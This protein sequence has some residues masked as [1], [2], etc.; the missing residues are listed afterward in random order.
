[1]IFKV[2]PFLSTNFGLSQ[3]PTFMK[4]QFYFFS[5]ICLFG[6]LNFINAQETLPI[7]DYAALQLMSSDTIPDY[8]SKANKL[9]LT[10]IIYESDGLTPAKDVILYVEQP[11]E[12]GDFD[13]RETNDKRYVHHRS[14]VKTDADGRYTLYTFVPGSDRRYNQ[15]QQ[16]FPIIK[17]SSKEAYELET[18]LFDDDPLLTKT[19]RKRMAKK[20]DPS[21][22]LKLK[23]V[24]G[25][26][27]AERNITLKPDEDS[28]KS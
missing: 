8:E 13:L 1:M 27:V 2:L 16:M 21:R 9:K 4:N 3:I 26:F 10:G 22:I 23:S 20:G 7:Y 6:T 28:A 24:D 19:C 12:N 17:E 11:D 18:F 5:F 25:I 14:W 15:L